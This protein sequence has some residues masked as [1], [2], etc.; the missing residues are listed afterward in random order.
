MP[1]AGFRKL[2][3][4]YTESTGTVEPFTETLAILGGDFKF[5][6]LANKGTFYE[7][8]LRTQQEMKTKAV[9][10]QFNDTLVN[11]DHAVDAD[12]FEGLKKRV[13][14][15]PARQTIDLAAAGD[16]LKVLANEANMQAFLDALHKAIKYVDGANALLCNETTQL[17]FGSMLRRL[18]LWTTMTDQHEHVWETFNKTTEMIT[19]TED[20]GD[21]G[22]DSTSIYAVRFDTSDGV[23][24]IE[25]EGAGG[26][27]VYDPLKGSEMEAGPQYLRRIDWPIGLT[28]K[29][30]YVICRIKGFKM[31]AA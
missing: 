19:S 5:D 10:F 28:H 31:A 17:Q 22:N 13:S 8:P 26:P 3:G 11:G 18:K 15:M 14:N 12:A 2:G 21:G 4:G 9:A 16:S 6:R 29:S 20:P 7:D 25:L 27:T 1:S 30:Q 23:H 24:A